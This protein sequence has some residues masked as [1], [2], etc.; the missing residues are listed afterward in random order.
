L[1]FDKVRLLLAARASTPVGAE[2]AR[3]LAP[4]TDEAAVR[5]VQHTVRDLADSA[6]VH[7]L[8]EMDAPD[9][10]PVLDRASVPGAVLSGEELVEIG[11][12]LVNLVR[13]RRHFAPTRSGTLNSPPVWRRR[14]DLAPSTGELSDHLDRCLDASG[15][16]RD[17]ATPTLARIRRDLTRARARVH[18]HLEGILATLS[19]ASGGQ[20]SYVTLRRGRYV[21]PVPAQDRSHVTGIVHDRSATH[22]TLFVE[23]VSSVPLNNAVEELTS[24]E[25]EEIQRILLALTDEVRDHTPALLDIQDLLARL[26]LDQ[27]R[28]RLS[29]HLHGTHPTVGG[30]ELRI[31][32]ARHPLLVNARGRDAV[33]PLSLT[34]DPATRVLLIT[35]PNAGGKTVALKTVGLLVLMSQAGLGIPSEEGSHLPVFRCVLADIG[36]FQSLEASLS[37]FTAHVER[38]R[39]IEREEGSDVLV[40]LD[41]VGG[42]TDPA[43]G[44][45]LG[46]A[47]LEELLERGIYAVMTTHISSLQAFAYGRPGVTLASMGFDAREGK[48]S[49]RLVPG[50][51][52]GS[53]ALEIAAREGLSERWIAR[54]RAHLDPDAEAARR[55]VAEVERLAEEARRDRETAA[56]TARR[57]VDDL[58]RA[59]AA[60]AEASAEAARVKRESR[61]AVRLE[62]A[63]ARRRLREAEDALK[64]ARTR[65]ELRQL[66]SAVDAVEEEQATVPEGRDVRQHQQPTLESLRPGVPVWI[67]SMNSAGTV[68]AGPD[69]SGRVAVQAGAF[70]SWLPPGALALPEAG[71]APQTRVRSAAPPAPP[72]TPEPEGRD[73]AAPAAARE[74][75]DQEVDVRGMRPD[76]AI[77]AVDRCL[78][79]A[80]LDGL[81]RI[82]IIHGKGRGVLR[83]HI[84]R[85]LARHAAVRSFELAAQWEGGTGAT[86][87]ELM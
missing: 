62:V 2:L 38:L 17:D 47:T 31:V 82:R 78:D 69:A 56:E 9:V 16:V 66:E 77:D 85:M 13:A 71:E 49:Y 20:A 74:Q 57:A 15:Q 46:M 14:L 83:E 54:A 48:P 51:G 36:D 3:G 87:V 5:D 86:T 28:V 41:E 67:P 6:G 43:E 29:R 76:E 26:D 81:S 35:G 37:T 32:E 25:A 23:P 75:I 7:G 11:R 64:T 73:V 42:A 33:L 40:L 21:I 68:V 63:R 61:D 8:C 72:P 22:A 24:A 18:E 44:A 50:P 12:V 79:R 70:R 1:E 34:L 4:E 10:R 55:M 27:A 60:R 52:G 84:Q 58:A 39:E 45:A 53:H 80:I 19:R 65:A 30:R 59:R